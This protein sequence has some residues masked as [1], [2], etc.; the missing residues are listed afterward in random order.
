MPILLDA[1]ENSGFAFFHDELHRGERCLCFV[2]P[3]RSGAVWGRRGMMDG[4]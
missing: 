1:I 3:D 2:G 4:L